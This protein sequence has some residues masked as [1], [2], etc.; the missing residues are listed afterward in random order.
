MSI[1]Y[2]KKAAK[3]PETETGNAQSVVAEMLA[4]I[5]AGGEQSVRDYAQKLDQWTGPILLSSEYIAGRSGEVPE[6]VK[7]DIEFAV[8]QVR[9]FA[10][11][12][13]QEHP[14]FFG[15]IA[16]GIEGWTTAGPG[17]CRRMLYTDRPIRAHRLGLYVDCDRE[18]RGC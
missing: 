4:T 5:E 8:N 13:T 18:I 16:A 17:Q 15:R 10:R 6:P 12:A 3:T 2:L 9:R 14:R 11:S 1:A 7:D